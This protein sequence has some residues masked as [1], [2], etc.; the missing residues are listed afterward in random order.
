MRKLLWPGFGEMFEP[1]A[2]QPKMIKLVFCF[3]RSSQTKYAVSK[4][5]NQNAVLRVQRDSI[6]MMIEN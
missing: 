4:D 6:P 1:L 2:I 5:I 3:W